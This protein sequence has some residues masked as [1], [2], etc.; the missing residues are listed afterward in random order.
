MPFNNEIGDQVRASPP[1]QGPCS[2]CLQTR[3]GVAPLSHTIDSIKQQWRRRSFVQEQ[4]KRLDQGLGAYLR[5]ELGWYRDMPKAEGDAIKAR[6]AQ[7]IEWGEAET[8]MNLLKA[9]RDQGEINGHQKRSLINAATKVYAAETDAAYR[10][11]RET[12][13]SALGAR[14]SFDR[15][16]DQTTAD[17]ES[18]VTSLPFWRKVEGVRGLGPVLVASVIGEAG[19]LGRYTKR[20][21]RKRM[22]LAPIRKDGVTKAGSAWRLGGGLT[23]DEWIIAGY[24]PKRRSRMFNI[25]ASLIKSGSPYARVYQSRKEYERERAKENGVTVAPAALIPKKERERYISD[26]QV[27]ARSQRYMEQ[28]LLEDLRKAWKL[29]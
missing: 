17:L 5:L 27:H 23:K 1:Q 16:E 9:M 24:S 8:R 10:L 19:D 7:L 21:L 3:E 25:G 11:H 2:G 12:I 20:G 28:R 13:L 18:L 22:G 6:A 14:A 26:G 15:V 4:R 29:P